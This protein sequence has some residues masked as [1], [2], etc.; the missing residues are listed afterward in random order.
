MKKTAYF[1][2]LSIFLLASCRNTTN[3]LKYEDTVNRLINL[4]LLAVLPE[5]GEQSAMWSS[6]DRRSR[7]D[8]LTDTYIEWYAN[9]DG[10]YQYIRMEGENEVLAE[11]EG[12]GAI[13]RIWSARPD[14]GHVKIY[15]DGSEE[16][17]VDLPFVDF[18]SGDVPPFNFKSLVY[19]A[20]E[21]CNN[22][23]PIPYQKSCKIVAE[24]GWGVYYH[25][26]YYTFKKNTKVENFSMDLSDE[27]NQALK[28]IDD[29][30]MQNMGNH[31]D[32]DSKNDSLIS[33]S[34][35]IKPGTSVQLINISGTRAI[36]SFKV[37]PSFK[38]R[39]DEMTGLRKLIL[40]MNWDGNKKPAVWTPLGDFFGTTPAINPY[41]SFP[42]GMTNEAFYAYWFMP[43]KESAL[44]Q[45]E[46]TGDTVYTFD[47]EIVLTPLE[48][49]NDK[50][51]RF[52]AWWHG[53]VLPVDEDRWPDWT[54]LETAGKGRYVGTMLHVMNPD[55]ESCKD[56][57][58]EGH[59]WWGEGDEKFFVDG[60]KFPSTF[61]TGTE[62]YFGYAWGNPAFF[63]KA[64]H[65]QSM[66]TGNTAHQSLNRWHI[67][68]NIPFQESFKGYIEKYY[69]EIC[70]T[71][72]NSVVY[73]YLSEDGSHKLNK[74]FVPIDRIMM[75][76]KI[77]LMN[78]YCLPGEEVTVQIE[79][80]GDEIRY[81]LD[82]SEPAKG[83][84]LYSKPLK[85]D[86]STTVTAKA[87][88]EEVESRPAIAMI[89]VIEWL[90]P[91]SAPENL[92]A[93]LNYRYFEKDGIWH[94]L[95]DFSQMQPAKTGVSA[96]VKLGMEER[97][98]HWG[99][100]FEGFMKID[101]KGLYTFYLN[102]D[103]GSKLFIND[104]LIINNDKTHAET[105]KSG[106]AALK[107][108]YYPIRIGFFE[109]ELS[110]VLEFKYSGPG[111]DKIEVHGSI[112]FH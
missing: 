27:A 87:F 75:P 57:A 4:E 26:N 35:S 72:Y 70:G 17:V 97:D 77:T 83:S 85:V 1:T 76:P 28:T 93:G 100:V 38:D 106:K 46:N 110:Q 50:Y 103:D 71:R 66:T 53:E 7:Y 81:T 19:R 43:F 112:L 48:E 78:N 68:D 108:G 95:P 91:Q 99:L 107:K 29:F 105:E 30:F 74:A 61:G 60:E 40:T 104:E 86:Y 111:I 101:K 15:I 54:L 20:S 62:D 11:M 44:V 8:E 49:P 82:G 94:E 25:F 6:Y 73:W 33:G 12:P 69:P 45:I 16:P 59:A 10:A 2:L 9:S 41:K 5:E 21:G 79:S 34:I 88:A 55:G 18:F 64:F 22:Y 39:E 92:N 36:K 31:P 37:F 52:H 63:E 65:S 56:A 51:G 102:S 32:P 13:V 14:T 90:E 23:V 58:G 84:T 109:N 24:P 42:A 67:S 3:T 98:E 47:F 96:S 89:K 80:P